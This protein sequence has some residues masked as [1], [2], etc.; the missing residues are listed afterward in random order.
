M[1]MAYDNEIITCS[2][3]VTVGSTVLYPLQMS[4]GSEIGSFN[5][6][7]CLLRNH[8]TLFMTLK[9]TQAHKEIM[10]QCF[11]TALLDYCY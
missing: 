11:T 8:S 2:L 9:S 7:H 6:C 4:I 3:K 10:Y 1:M 5:K